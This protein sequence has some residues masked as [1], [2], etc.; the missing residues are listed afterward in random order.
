MTHD[1]E[2]DTDQDGLRPRHHRIAVYLDPETLT[3]FEQ[4]KAE[5]GGKSWSE[6][7][8]VNAALGIFLGVP[9]WKDRQGF[10]AAWKS[11]ILRPAAMRRT[12][13]SGRLNN[14]GLYVVPPSDGPEEGRPNITGDNLL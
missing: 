3:A 14:P 8:S 11:T 9:R 13:S 6:S 10:G 4:W 12:S 7:S 2:R 5:H 1:Q